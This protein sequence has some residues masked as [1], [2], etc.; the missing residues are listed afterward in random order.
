MQLIKS[1]V[2]MLIIC[3]VVGSALTVP[4]IYLDY[5]VRKE[6]ISEVL[7]VNRDKPITMCEGR[8]YL[9]DQLAQ[10]QNQEESNK[11]IGQL[12]EINFFLSEAILFAAETSFRAVDVS[13]SCLSENMKMDDFV[14]RSLRPPQFA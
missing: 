10:A 9:S 14:T 2:V 8:C 6:Y 11:S 3:S 5:E 4:L 13:F 12:F 1:T 7:C